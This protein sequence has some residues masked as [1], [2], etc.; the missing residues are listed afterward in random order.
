MNID[1]G[2]WGWPQWTVLILMFLSLGVHASL[3]NKPKLDEDGN[4]QKYNGFIALTRFA[5]LLF[6]L[7]AGG[8]YA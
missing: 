6:L 1:T 8:F 3:H 5:L 7:I 2:G 4:P